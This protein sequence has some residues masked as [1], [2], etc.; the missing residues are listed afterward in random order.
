MPPST[1][2][3]TFYL[4]LSSPQEIAGLKLDLLGIKNLV[5]WSGQQNHLTSYVNHPTPH[6]HLTL[7]FQ[8]LAL[9][10][11]LDNTHSSNKQATRS[12]NL[13][14]YILNRWTRELPFLSQDLD[15]DKLDFKR[16]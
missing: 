15:L 8:A 9:A 6:P 7:A 3:F 14:I 16:R 4:S 1:L 13:L 5:Q 10:F 2:H 11:A 12:S